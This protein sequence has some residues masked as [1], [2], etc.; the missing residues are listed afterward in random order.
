MATDNDRNIEW[1]PEEELVWQLLFDKVDRGVNGVGGARRTAAPEP[2]MPPPKDNINP[3][4]YKVGG[5]ETVEYMKAKSTKE[6]FRGHLRLTAIKY[7][8]RVGHKGDSVKELLDEY[9]KARW[10]IERLI[11]DITE[12]R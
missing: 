5:I 7:L 11:R 6:E 3:V 4:H 2:V 9:G 8:S 12:R 1:T 10:Y